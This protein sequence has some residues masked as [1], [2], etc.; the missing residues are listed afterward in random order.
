MYTK[1]EVPADRLTGKSE[2]LLYGQP[3]LALFWF[4]FAH[5]TETDIFYTAI[6]YALSAVLYLMLV[7][8][9]RKKELNQ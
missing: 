9:V 3:I 7:K 5:I 4:M 1:S 2:L 8:L 6:I